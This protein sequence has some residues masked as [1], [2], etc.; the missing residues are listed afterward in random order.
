MA[1]LT[2]TDARLKNVFF[3]F[4]MFSLCERKSKHSSMEYIDA[5]IYK[6]KLYNM[7]FGARGDL[8]IILVRDFIRFKYIM[9]KI[10]LIITGEIAS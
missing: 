8:Q 4:K 7:P 2:L 5:L 9:V 10:L 3:F 1:F 6:H